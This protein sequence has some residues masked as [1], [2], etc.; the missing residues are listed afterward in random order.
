MVLNTDVKYSLNIDAISAG[1]EAVR[2]GVDTPLPTPIDMVSGKLD[3]L[4][5]SLNTDQNLFG[6]LRRSESR[7]LNRE[8]NS[9]GLLLLISNSKKR[10]LL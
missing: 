3:S 10:E 9:F 4:L 5:L 6:L 2:V 1:L 8:L 7:E